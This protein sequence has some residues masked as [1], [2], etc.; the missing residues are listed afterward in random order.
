[1]KKLLLH[2][3]AVFSFA[4]ASAQNEYLQNNPQW[5]VLIQRSQ[6][7]PCIENDTTNYYING[8]TIINALTYKKL[9]AKGH[10][11]DTWW[12][13]NPN[14]SCYANYTYTD[15]VP[16]G[17]LRSSGAQMYYMMYGDTSEQLLYD[18]NLTVG[19]QLP[20]TSVYASTGTYVTSIDSIY[21]PYGYRKRFYIDG[22][23]SEY[24]LEGIG[25]R[26][27]LVE[28]FGPMM[29]ATHTLLCFGF[30]DTAWFPTQGPEC[31]V[32]TSN[33]ELQAS[34][35]LRVVPN[36]ASDH[37]TVNLTGTAL[38]SVALYNV[39][40]QIVKQ[41]S[42]AEVYVGDLSPGIYFVRVESDAGSFTSELVIE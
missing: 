12:S 32:I 23:S 13:P 19:S 2:L 16:R 10:I 28:P 5:T 8:D 41:Q 17:F 20:Q 25:S 34:V 35:Q 18:Y 14:T 31:A 37:I 33:A 3:F 38:N 1:M 22:N 7:Y 30:N 6:F 39:H 21:T 27:G 9:F 11:D 40:G 15:L 4:G 36:P 42:T 26:Y 24:I 29:D